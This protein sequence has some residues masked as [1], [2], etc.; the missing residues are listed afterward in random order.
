MSAKDSLPHLVVI[1]NPRKARYYRKMPQPVEPA[2]EETT[3]ADESAKGKKKAA[4][5]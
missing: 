1:A 3:S 2:S 4:S 5:A